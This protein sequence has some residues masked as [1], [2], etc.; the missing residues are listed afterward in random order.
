ML[1]VERGFNRT[2]ECAQW[3][4]GPGY[5]DSSTPHVEVSVQTRAQISMLH[6][7]QEK[8]LIPFC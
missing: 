7:F 6:Y 8:A 3:D 1:S 5:K 2:A 4:N